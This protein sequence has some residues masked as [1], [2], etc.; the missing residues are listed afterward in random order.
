[1]RRV[2]AVL[3]LLLLP[4]LGS[5]QDTPY[6]TDTDSA[7]PIDGGAVEASGEVGGRPQCGCASVGAPA[8]ILF[9]GLVALAALSRRAS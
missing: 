8:T 4:V 7:F 6:D 5:A 3:A 9:A 2:L 1:M